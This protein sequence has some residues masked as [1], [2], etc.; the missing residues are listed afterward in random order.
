[1]ARIHAETVARDRGVQLAQQDVYK[2]R[3]T[4]SP[5]TEI[6]SDV[7]SGR[8]ATV[9]DSQEMLY[10]SDLDLTKTLGECGFIFKVLWLY[11]NSTSRKT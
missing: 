11:C 1:M 3:R 7:D 6:M 8:G 9:A 4:N 5:Q 10:R 2:S